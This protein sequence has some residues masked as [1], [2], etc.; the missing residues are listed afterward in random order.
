MVNI[1]LG[2]EIESSFEHPLKTLFPTVVKEAV[3]VTPDKSTQ[4]WKTVFAKEVIPAG[5]VIV[6]IPDD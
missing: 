2:K 3:M 5:I 6:R 4:F 1:V